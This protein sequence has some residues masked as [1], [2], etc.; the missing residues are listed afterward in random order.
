[1]TTSRKN[2]Y[3]KQPLSPFPKL[4]NNRWILESYIIS[5]MLIFCFKRQVKQNIDF[6]IIY[7]IILILYQFC[8]RV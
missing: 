7:L 5:N 1:M 2:R 6:N 4:H 8:V 3:V